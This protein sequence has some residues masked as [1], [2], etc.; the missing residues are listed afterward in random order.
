M[1]ER[2]K[3]TNG[4]FSWAE[5]ATTDQ[6]AAKQFYSAV[7]GW[8][9]TDNPIGEGMVYSVASVDGKD[10]GAISAQMEQQ[11]D[12]GAPPAWQSYVTVDSADAAA[13]KVAPLGGTVH[14][15]PFDVMD[16][17]RM[18]VIQ[19]PQG[20]FFAIWEPKTNIGAQLVNAPG[21]LSW[22]ELATTDMDAAGQFYGGLF[23]WT[24]EPFEGSETPYA[25]I[26]TAAGSSTGGIR[27]T[28]GP[29]PPN[30]VVYFGAEDTAASAAKVLELGGNQLLEPTDIP[31]GQIA[32][33][34]DPQG[35]VFALY[36]GQFEP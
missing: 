29:E 26:K 22:D 32:I 15:P 2:T 28:M 34:Q 23:G 19:D 24:T 21:A 3:Y 27:P 25:V 6:D 12:A 16:L 9:V 8:D 11:R 35:A 30:W 1:G 13:E 5:L 33:M 36:S 18:A 17:G 7:F 31:M 20:A 10:V 14:A 4:T